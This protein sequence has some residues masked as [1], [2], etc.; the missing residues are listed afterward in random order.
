MMLGTSPSDIKFLFLNEAY[1]SFDISSDFILVP[2]T[3]KDV[4]HGNIDLATGKTI[5]KSMFAQ[6]K[7]KGDYSLQDVYGYKKVKYS[8]GQP[9]LTFDKK[10]NNIYI[11]KLIN[12]WGDGMYASEYYLDNKPS[13]L[14]NGSVK[15]TQ[16]I[17]DNDIINFY[18]PSI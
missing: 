11:Y 15:I 5:T 2:R 18:A 6:R 10:G 9:L 14:N 8:N 4:V 16:E 13:V 1:N 7:A 17:S 3:I 12:L